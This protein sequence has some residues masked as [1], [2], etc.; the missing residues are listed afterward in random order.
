MSKV[1]IF[2]YSIILSLFAVS[3][4]FA[5]PVPQSFVEVAERSMPAVV[6]I[7]TTYKVK[8]IEEQ[9]MDLN[10]LLR[11]P[12]PFLNREPGE[13]EKDVPLMRSLGSGF[14]VDP[15]GYVVTNYHVIEK[16]DEIKVKLNGEDKEYKAK[17]VGHDR[18]T[19]LALL[20][21]ESNEKF[22]FLE[23]GDSDN[24]KVGE[25]V[26]AIGNPFGLGSTVTAGIISAKSRALNIGY[27]DF[28]QTDASI[29]PGNSGGPMLDMNGKVI[30]VNNL[31]YTA[32]KGGNLGIGFGIPSSTV[33]PI[34]ELLKKDGKVVRSWLGVTV[35]KITPDISEK[36]RLDKQS[37]V[38]FSSIMKGGPAEKAGLMVGDILIKFNGQNITNSNAVKVIAQTPV[39]K[40]VEAEIIRNG[41]KLIVE[42]ITEAS[43]EE[44]IHNV[45][46][47]EKGKVYFGMRVSDINDV[48]RKR[49]SIPD[50][51]NGVVVTEVQR[52]SMTSFVGIVPGVVITK[53]NNENVSNMKEFEAMMEKIAK[54]KDSNG[55]LFLLNYRGV[56]QF[57]VLKEE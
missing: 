14:I 1:Q 18:K 28:I 37:G 6:N 38:I 43:K 50:A 8:A 55:V 2:L 25:W 31:I 3:A 16:A 35:Q 9:Q 10:D 36:L 45:A 15:A 12:W 47:A 29:N 40:K 34:I 54:D 23:F 53:V 42:V 52:G 27:D 26:L 51:V 22:P 24:S 5:S 13:M 32:G 33:A 19:D 7:A 41:A 46:G 17:V 20:K 30:G 49:F 44:E 11:N 48:M 4:S 39:G 56:S 57:V 21:I